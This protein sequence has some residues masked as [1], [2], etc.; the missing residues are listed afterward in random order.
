MQEITRIL[1]MKEVMTTHPS[2]S[3]IIQFLSLVRRIFHN[4]KLKYWL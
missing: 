1:G 4:Q 2:L 3:I